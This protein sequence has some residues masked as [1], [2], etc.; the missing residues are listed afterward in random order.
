MG[1][2]VARSDRV[3][4]AKASNS[5]TSNRYRFPRFFFLYAPYTILYIAHLPVRGICGR[6]LTQ[7]LCTSVNSSNSRWMRRERRSAGFP[8]NFPIAAPMCTKSTIRNPLTPTSCSAFLICYITI[9]LLF[10]PMNIGKVSPISEYVDLL[11]TK[12]FSFIVYYA[13]LCQKKKNI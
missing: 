6:Y 7:R 1:F 12:L 11:G 4:N 5:G 13:F 8:A 3:G 10:I 9:S 2:C